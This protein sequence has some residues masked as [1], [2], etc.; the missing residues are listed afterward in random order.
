MVENAQARAGGGP[1]RPR[2]VDEQHQR[3]QSPDLGFVGHQ[4]SEQPA[5]AYRLGGKILAKE[6]ITRAGCI[7]L[8]E[9]E[10]NDGQHRVKT[11]GQLS[12]TRDAVRDARVSDLSFG[13]D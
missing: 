10:V 4:L 9:D 13:A 8:V 1:P 11:I 2:G 3:E 5:E 7:S 12:L 6:V